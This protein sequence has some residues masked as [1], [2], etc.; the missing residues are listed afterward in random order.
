MLLVSVP[1]DGA[2]A[3]TTAWRNGRFNVDVPGVVSESNIL[4]G[5]PNLQNTQAMPIGNGTLDG[6]VWSVSAES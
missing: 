2:D 1:A 5:Q 4:L 6:A 3:L